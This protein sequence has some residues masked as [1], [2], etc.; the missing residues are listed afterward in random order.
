MPKIKKKTISEL[1]TTIE[2]L[3]ERDYEQIAIDIIGDDPELINHSL[4][5]AID[6][7]SLTV[8]EY[9]ISKQVNIEAINYQGKTALY[10]ATELGRT[11][12]VASL[13][14][15]NANINEDLTHNVARLHSHP[16][17]LHAAAEAGYA[18]IVTLLLAQPSIDLSTYYNGANP[19]VIAIKKGHHEIVKKLI[20]RG[21][22]LD[23]SSSCGETPLTMAITGRHREIVELLL[24]HK[25]SH[26][27]LNTHNKTPLQIAIT[28]EDEELVKL[29]LKN[30]AEINL[31]VEGKTPLHTAVATNNKQMAEFLL[32]YGASPDTMGRETILRRETPLHLAIRSENKEMVELLLAHT[33]S[34]NI[35]NSEGRTPLQMAITSENTKIVELLLAHGAS[36]NAI[37][38][39]TLFSN[40]TPLQMAITGGNIKIVN[41]LL[42]HG[43]S[44]NILNSYG[45]TPLQMAITGGTIKI[46][47]SLLAHGASP[48]TVGSDTIFGR[49]TPLQMAINDKNKEMVELLLAHEA[50]A[51]QFDLTTLAASEDIKLQLA[52]A[53]LAES[54]DSINQ[55]FFKL[56]ANLT[57]APTGPAQTALNQPLSDM[58]IVAFK[59]IVDVITAP[60]QDNLG[61]PEANFITN[62]RNWLIQLKKDIKETPWQ[63][64]NNPITAVLTQKEWK[65]GRPNNIETMSK[66]LID[67]ESKTNYDIAKLYI[68]IMK[69]LSNIQYSTDQ[70]ETTST[71]YKQKLAE[72]LTDFSQ[73]SDLSSDRCPLPSFKPSETDSNFAATREGE[74]ASSSNALPI[75]HVEVPPTEA[76][77]NALST[78]TSSVIISRASIFTASSS[79]NSNEQNACIEMKDMKRVNR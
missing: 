37:G 56:Y 64:K 55:I 54:G 78:P 31:L 1:I 3:L 47:E 71:F 32:K 59:I 65:D 52:R 28:N 25:A 20:A 67:L 22:A 6:Y 7:A 19:L 34:L 4:F 17:P 68:L 50:K 48:N 49:E 42:A 58:Q 33:E 41:L 51:S 35:I 44:P 61:T 29:L 23:I 74:K 39:G 14:K 21:A 38:R 57:A 76:D 72:L 16:S 46:V 75:N 26:S 30:G 9:L 60:D 66:M 73:T 5:V 18:E 40:E 13:L 10:L 79:K 27:K 70:H 63:V 11:E 2:T 62:L 15:A 69:Q 24:A 43:A 77:E 8:V 36:A 53:Q 12:I 45:K